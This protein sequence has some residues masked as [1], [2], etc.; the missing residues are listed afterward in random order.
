MR[1]KKAL[2]VS[3]LASILA[4]TIATPSYGQ[5]RSQSSATTK[6][7][8][9]PQ[10]D[11]S[12]SDENATPKEILVLGVR[13]AVEKAV[14]NKKKA[15][16]IVESVVAE[17]I[18]KLPDNNVTEAISRLT[19]VQIDRLRGE[20]G[21]VSIRG[22]G[23]VQT[24]INGQDV[25]T[26]SRRSTS[27]TDIPAELIKAVTVYKTR[28]ADQ[29]EGGVAGTVNVELRRPL[30][31][32]KN[33]LVVAGS[34]R[35]KFGDGDSTY[36]PYYSALVGK[37]FDTGLG[38]MGF[39]LNGAYSVN[40]YAENY[41]M[42]E[43]VG[44]FFAL[45][46][47]NLPANLRETLFAPFRANYQVE[48]GRTKR[49]S[50]NASFQW[51]PTAGLTITAETQYI[52]SDNFNRYDK[53]YATLR[54]WNS[55]LTS[56]TTIDGTGTKL[57]N[58]A[59]YTGCPNSPGPSAG[60]TGGFTRDTSKTWVHNFE[61]NYNK[62]RFSA[63]AQAN[64]NV[65]SYSAYAV[66]QNLI[67]PNLKAVTVNFKGSGF[68]ADAPMV[69]FPG[70][71]LSNIANYREGTFTDRLTYERSRYFSTNLDLR[72]RVSDTAFIRDLQIGGRYSSR[73]NSSSYGYRDAFP[74]R[75]VSP[76]DFPFAETIAPRGPI[77]SPVRWL[78]ADTEALY[79]GIATIREFIVA[80]PTIYGAG[81]SG[82][83]ARPLPDG[84]NSGTY[85]SIERT[86]SVFGNVYYGFN[87]AQIPVSGVLGVRGARTYG[88][89]SSVSTFYDRN[90][91]PIDQ[92]RTGSGDYWDWMPSFNGRAELTKRL[93]LR[94]AYTKNIQR[95]GFQDLTSWRVV[96]SNTGRIYSGNPEL[97]TV[98]TQD[99]NLEL[100]YSLPRSGFASLGFFRK[101]QE[102]FLFSRCQE[103]LSG[104]QVGGLGTPNNGT[105]W[106][107]CK[108]R[109]A[110]PGRFAG[111]EGQIQKFFDFL[112]G[113]LKHFGIQANATHQLQYTLLYPDWEEF[114]DVADDKDLTQA[115]NVSKWTLNGT[116][117]YDTPM[118][119]ARVS[120]NW[121]G[122]FRTGYNQDAPQYSTYWKATSTL[123]AAINWT[124]KRFVTFSVEGVNLLK[125]AN[126]SYY[127]REY[128]MPS[129]TRLRP[130]YIQASVRMRY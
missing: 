101:A 24:T 108:L 85:T 14:E 74:L 63:S 47:D 1:N 96:E 52:K 115:D 46:A 28:T 59:T 95:A 20:G 119:S 122:P 9:S 87:I 126:R 66:F 120:Y 39:L 16:Q 121:R 78:A 6:A 90:W 69:S 91:N 124:P 51:R 26:G 127:G 36:S 43:S 62:G 18:G 55:C 97:Q 56:Y 5:T 45:A 42:A 54:E 77:G 109:N 38:E 65:S 76:T 34:Y 68:E 11:D 111:I 110:G 48:R 67:L 60:V 58:S 49:P 25:A 70:V 116:L 4:I 94:A 88:W 73:P 61:V 107:E 125:N 79:D 99:Y 30:D 13:G 105:T 41:S 44:T 118:L 32:E 100:S 72:Y 81:G 86:M 71:D 82:R 98:K 10:T 29:V 93:A 50:I 128:L 40:E 3:S 117:L 104:D 33:K 12:A 80:N 130:R 75:A 102:G 2:T 64:Y 37:N 15:T 17:D 35:A 83:W 129:E 89:V 113:E 114:V 21:S 53:L 7:K 8:S 19:G 123:D 92:V 27:L 22:L 31:L 103:G 112:P 23:G 106:T 57:I 84:D